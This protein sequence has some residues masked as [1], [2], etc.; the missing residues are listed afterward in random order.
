LGSGFVQPVFS[1]PS[2]RRTSRHF[3]TSSRRAARLKA[4]CVLGHALALCDS[5]GRTHQTGSM[6]RRGL[7]PRRRGLGDDLTL[8][9]GSLTP[10]G[11]RHNA[12]VNR[13]TRAMVTA[14]GDKAIVQVCSLLL[15]NLPRVIGR[16]PRHVATPLLTVPMRWTR[17]MPKG[18]TH[19][20][21]KPANLM[22][23]PRGQVKVLDFG[24]AKTT[25]S[26][27]PIPTRGD[28]W[29]TDRRRHVSRVGA[30]HE[31]RAGVG[32]RGGPAQ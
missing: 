15:R 17:R 31:P 4:L 24:V 9:P 20:D 3:P 7:A 6:G 13:A 28:H 18:L 30:V 16:N 10:I 5:A 2:R 27:S 29:G 1:P 32:A 22:L 14:V 25:R 21:I 19:R 26:E 11:P 23:T 12:A 8:S